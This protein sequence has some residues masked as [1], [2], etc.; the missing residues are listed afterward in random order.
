[1]FSLSVCLIVRDEEKV[2]LRVLNCVKQFADE[3]IV[4]DTGSKDRTK[5]I[6]QQFT[7]KIFDFEWEDDFSKARNFSFS[8]ATKDYIMWI[9]A[10]DYITE[11]NIQ[12]ILALK[13][14]NMQNDVF[15]LKYLMGFNEEDKPTFS[16]YRERILKR[17]CN[18]KWQGFIH[19]AIS[20]SGKIE[21]LDI[22][23]EHRKI[24]VKDEKRNL[25]IYRN[26]I[27]RNYIFNA[28]ETYYY[29]RELYYCGYYTLCIKSMK[30]L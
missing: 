27:K 10:D 11:E 28:R 15:M 21:Y 4:V 20:V 2:I 25:K 23:I 18:F 6:A 26:A 1:M 24:E 8:K 9:D 5:Q 29:A 7:T 13:Q 12:K 3:I 22:E 14:K 17:S 16:F 30:K 19:E